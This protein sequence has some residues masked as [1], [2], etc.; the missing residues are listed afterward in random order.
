[1]THLLRRPVRGD[2]FSVP[3]I[4][5]EN[6]NKSREHLTE[7]FQRRDEVSEMSIHQMDY[8]KSTGKAAKECRLRRKTGKNG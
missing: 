2:F 5:S 3:S 6:T 8:D 1:M 4:M 7:V